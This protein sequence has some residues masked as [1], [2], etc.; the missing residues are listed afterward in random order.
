MGHRPNIADIVTRHASG[1][2]ALCDEARS[3]TKSGSKVDEALR[4]LAIKCGEVILELR[5]EPLKA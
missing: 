4:D 1:M 5:K 2:M 3:V